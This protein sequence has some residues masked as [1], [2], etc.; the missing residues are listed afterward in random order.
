MRKIGREPRLIAYDT[1]VNIKRRQA[2][3]APV[4]HWLRPR[5]LLYAGLI[6]V[7]GAVMLFA[8]VERSVYGVAVIHDRNPLF[9]RLSSGAIRNAYLVRLTSKASEPKRFSLS[10]TGLPGPVVGVVGAEFDAWGNEWIDVGPDKTREVRVL[11]TADH[12]QGGSVP[13]VFA[14]KAE[15]G[16][17]E[18]RSSD[19]FFGP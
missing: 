8:L 19:H 18:V 4:Y 14:A 15:D 1:D 2:G 13:L 10:V 17:A 16:K 6:A 3:L 12:T 9:V 5:T 7:V 11:V